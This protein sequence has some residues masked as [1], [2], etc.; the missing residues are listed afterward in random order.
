MMGKKF[1]GCVLSFCVTALLSACA[2]MSPEE[3][4]VAD[5]REV[6][7]RDGLRGEP[8]SQLG[9]H[10]ES[11]SKAGVAINAQAY[12]QGRDVGLRS[13]CRLE[14]AVPLGLSGGHYSGV[15]PPELDAA[16][17]QRY[18]VA[19]AVH[20]LRGEVRSLDERT[21]MLERRLRDSN[22]EEDKRLKEARTD[23]ERKKVRKTMDDERHDIR[24]QLEDTD[25]RLRRKRDDLRSAEFSLSNLR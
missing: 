24:T 1:L 2:T 14:N 6:G 17:Q 13:Y 4:K 19:R 16:F 3:C 23:D 15:C 21:E 11:C 5:W 25:H 8:L 18:Q 22:H 12:R 20:D 7:Q 10:A 9:A